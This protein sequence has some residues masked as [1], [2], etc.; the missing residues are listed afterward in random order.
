VYR[1]REQFEHLTELL[2]ARVVESSLPKPAQI[3]KGKE[4]ESNIPH[5][6]Y[7]AENSRKN[8]MFPT[9]AS[10]VLVREISN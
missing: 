2:R 7:V 1:N 10:T 8:V 9:S 5:R 6:E 3:S 4:V